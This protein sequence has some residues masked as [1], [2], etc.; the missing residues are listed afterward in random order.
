MTIVSAIDNGTGERIRQRGNS[1]LEKYRADR[2]ESLMPQQAGARERTENDD[3]QIEGSKFRQDLP[4]FLRELQSTGGCADAA[5]AAAGLPAEA[6]S[7]TAFREPANKR[8]AHYSIRLC[9]LTAR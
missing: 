4:G 7:L 9:N 6:A 8:I 1:L 3:S 5:T 2:R